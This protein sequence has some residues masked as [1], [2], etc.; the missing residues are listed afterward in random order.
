M[1]DPKDSLG[2]RMKE[3]REGVY[4][5]QISGAARTVTGPVTFSRPRVIV[6]QSIAACIKEHGN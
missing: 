2:D 5:N 4:E 1:I 3:A 6:L